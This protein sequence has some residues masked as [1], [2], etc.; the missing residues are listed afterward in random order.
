MIRDGVSSSF[1]IDLTELLKVIDSTKISELKSLIN[2]I[3]PKSVWLIGGDGWAYDIGF[4]GID[5]V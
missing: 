4:Y 3:Y 5:H 1:K 2:Y